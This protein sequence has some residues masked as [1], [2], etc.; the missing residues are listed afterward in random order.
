MLWIAAGLALLAGMASLAAAV[1]GIVVLNEIFAFVQEHKAD[2]ATAELKS[3]MPA[4]ARVRRDGHTET[5][6]A[7]DLVRDDV[8]LIGAGDRIA[9]DN[10]LSDA[11]GLRANRSS[12]SQGGAALNP[13]YPNDLHCKSP[14]RDRAGLEEA[15]AGP[16]SRRAVAARYKNTMTGSAGS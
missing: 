12:Q 13:R 5:V 14:G 1:I 7:V 10:R 6:D 2:K 4:T 16:R 9:A 15:L 8:V 11:Q 3:M